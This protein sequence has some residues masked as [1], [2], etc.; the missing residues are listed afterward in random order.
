MDIN[1]SLEQGPY[2][3]T[4]INPNLHLP[5]FIDDGHLISVDQ[6]VPKTEQTSRSAHIRSLFDKSRPK[7]L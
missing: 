1:S 2:S 5:I 6:E 3:Q 4:I 7:H